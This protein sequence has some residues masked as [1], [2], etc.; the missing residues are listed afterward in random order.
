[1]LA[2]AV[3]IVE[4]RLLRREVRGAPRSHPAREATD[5][6]GEEVEEAF[7][8]AFLANPREWN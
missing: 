8:W 4:V 7:L 2:E 3:H 6:G 5:G 1:M